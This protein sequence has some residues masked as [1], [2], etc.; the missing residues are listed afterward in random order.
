MRRREEDLPE[1][2]NLQ[3]TGTDLPSVQQ[4]IGAKL[5]QD[6]SISYIVTL[7]ADYA[8][9]AAEARTGANSQA[10]VATF[11]LNKDAAQAIKDQK[12]LF[13]VDQQPYLQGFMSVQMLYLN[14]SNGNDLGGG[15]PVLTG[16]SYVDQSNID[17]ILE[18]ANNNTR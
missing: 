12:I 14:M 17:Q 6:P 13:A 18:F 2:E 10:K 8:L 9:V 16:P 1:L 7:G 5:Q 3:V 11:D 4:T 15:K